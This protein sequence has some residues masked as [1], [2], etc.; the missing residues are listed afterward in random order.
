M[1]FLPRAPHRGLI[2]AWK[3]YRMYR[4]TMIRTGPGSGFFGKDMKSTAHIFKGR[5]EAEAQAKMDKFLIGAQL[6]GS[7]HLELVED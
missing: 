4:G 1:P 2:M 7:F 3:K 6:S 5:T